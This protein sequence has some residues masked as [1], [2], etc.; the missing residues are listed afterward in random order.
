MTLN[1]QLTNKGFEDRLSVCVGGETKE[2]TERDNKIHFEIS[3]TTETTVRVQYVR[4]DIHRIKTPIGRFFAYLLLILLSPIIFFADNDNGIG[5]HKFFH[6]AKP[7]DLKKV[8]KI[9]PTENM[10]SLKYLYPTYDKEARRFSVPDVE[11]TGAEAAEETVTAEYNRAVVR[12]EFRLYHYPAYTVLFAVNIA[13][14]LLM[15]ICLI[16]Q[17]FPFDLAGVILMSLCCLVTLALLIAFICV[18]VST[19]RLLKQIEKDSTN[20][21]LI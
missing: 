17:F 14:N 8:F 12:K 20:Q 1:F 15:M 7:Y 21:M 3:D 11:L 6:S 16:N 9:D 10:I 18:F 2:L 5:I 4:N 13:L 19:H